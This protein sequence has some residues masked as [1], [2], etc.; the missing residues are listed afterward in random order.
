MQVKFDL[1]AWTAEITVQAISDA[2]GLS[3]EEVRDY[4]PGFIAAYV[5]D[6]LLYELRTSTSMQKHFASY[7]ESAKDAKAKKTSKRKSV[8]V[9]GLA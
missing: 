8:A 2:T 9:I 4:L 5:V 7:V 6:D 1:P 3:D